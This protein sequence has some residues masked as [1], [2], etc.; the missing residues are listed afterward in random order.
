MSDKFNA[1][2]V[3]ESLELFFNKA[4]IE[5][6]TN[7]SQFVFNGENGEGECLKSFSAAQHACTIVPTF[8]RAFPFVNNHAAVACQLLGMLEGKSHFVTHFASFYSKTQ[9]S[10]EKAVLYLLILM[11]G[12]IAQIQSESDE[13]LKPLLSRVEAKFVA[14]VDTA[15]VRLDCSGLGA[16]YL[17]T[18]ILLPR[19]RDLFSAFKYSGLSE[20]IDALT[21]RAKLTELRKLSVEPR[22]T[23][24]C[25]P[26]IDKA[27]NEKIAYLKPQ[28]KLNVEQVVPLHAQSACK[29]SSNDVGS[30]RGIFHARTRR[31][32]K[33]RIITKKC[34]KSDLVRS[35][36]TTKDRKA[37]FFDTFIKDSK[38]SN[39]TDLQISPFDVKAK[40]K[41]GEAKRHKA[42][43]KHTSTL[44]LIPKAKPSKTRVIKSSYADKYVTKK[45]SNADEYVINLRNVNENFSKLYSDVMTRNSYGELDGFPNAHN[46]ETNKPFTSEE[47][48]LGYVYVFDENQASIQFADL[49]NEI[50]AAKTPVKNLLGKFGSA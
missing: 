11:L 25:T 49:C 3:A 43:A 22:I 9:F 48:E 44:A 47:S 42:I 17:Q 40:D 38:Q 26:K 10:A 12:K 32:S 4:I 27:R 7:A 5:H 8:L 2:Y 6:S 35:E 20:Y 15:A 36:E 39:K 50:Q 30:T 41:V 24:E 19:L 23:L 21:K 33:D 31:N 18:H 46:C 14:E 45:K 1:K 16:N 29:P 13:K 37:A 34:D 28:D